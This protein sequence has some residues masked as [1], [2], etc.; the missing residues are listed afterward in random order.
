MII[1]AIHDNLTQMKKGVFKCLVFQIMLDNISIFHCSRIEHNNKCVYNISKLKTSSYNLFTSFP[2]KMW[3]T[4]KTSIFLKVC[5]VLL[6]FVIFASC[7]STKGAKKK[8]HPAL[9]NTV[10]SM[11]EEEVK[12]NLGEPDIVSRTPDNHIIWTYIP[13]W[14][15][16]PDNKGTVYIEFEQGKVIKIIKAR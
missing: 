15:I 4:T 7:G 14:K 3:K 8:G 2:Q 13:S 5:S 9:E 11:N 10:I 12:R 6:C 16:M 1:W